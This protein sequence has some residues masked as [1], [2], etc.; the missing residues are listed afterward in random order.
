METFYHG[1]YRLF[2]HF[3]IAHLGEGEGKFKF[4]QGIYITSSYATAA[5]Y[6]AKAGKANGVDTYYV[7]TLEVP[8]LTEDNH[9][10][11]C[12]SVNPAIVKRVEE[13]LG[14][15]IPEDA[16][17]AGKLF[18]KYV[19]NLK[20]GKIGTVKQMTGKA[21][22]EAENAASVFLREQGII[23]LAWPQAQTKPDGET[24]RAVLDSTLIKIVK[25]EQVQVDAKNKLIADSIT[26][27]KR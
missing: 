16:L 18:R 6:A 12:R 14:T 1:T 11:S 9:V 10:F 27:V 26:E 8:D 13:A 25:I 4:G 23:Y 21:D 20:V 7:Y 17:S 19:G 2:N 15:S 3:D 5:L 22:A 24:N